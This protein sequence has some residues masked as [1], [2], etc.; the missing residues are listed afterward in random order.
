MPRSKSNG[1]PGGRAQYTGQNAYASQGFENDTRSQLQALGGLAYAYLAVDRVIVT[2]DQTAI[3]WGQ[4]PTPL[5]GWNN[6]FMR[7][8]VLQPDG[9][10]ISCTQPG[11]YKITSAIRLLGIPTSGQALSRINIS[12]ASGGSFPSPIGVWGNSAAIATGQQI[13]TTI[14]LIVDLQKGTNITFSIN[15]VTGITMGGG[16]TTGIVI[17][18]LD[19]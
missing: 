18:Q 17:E 10:T 9:A 15:G 12:N 19:I 7:G 4:I 1:L 13:L 5:S 6:T 2:A 16:Q 11:T 14:P 8:F 3:V